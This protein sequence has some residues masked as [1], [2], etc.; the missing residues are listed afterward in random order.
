M[1]Q[2]LQCSGVTGLLP[3]AS[4]Q[5]GLPAPLCV[6]SIKQEFMFD[7]NELQIYSAAASHKSA[8]WGEKQHAGLGSF[9]SEDL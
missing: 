9:A 6:C 4:A 7:L 3:V 1:P 5:L 8:W 2:L